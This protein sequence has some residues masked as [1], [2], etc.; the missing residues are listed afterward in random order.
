MTRIAHSLQ[1]HP[2]LVWL[3]SLALLAGGLELARLE[4]MDG[5]IGSLVTLLL[6]VLAV[7]FLIAGRIGVALTSWA[8][9]WVQ[10]VVAGGLMTG[11]ALALDRPLRR[12]LSRFHN[13]PRA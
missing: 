2:A 8:P 9:V 3:A 5:G 4:A 13:A 6:M 7:P 11:V 10:L 12:W 1:Q